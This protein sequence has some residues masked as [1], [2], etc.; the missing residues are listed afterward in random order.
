M[1]EPGGQPSYATQR[2]VRDPPA[3]AAARSA[4]LRAGSRL[5]GSSRKP[6]L[7]LM[8]SPLPPAGAHL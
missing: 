3:T 1:M 6:S 8:Q 4:S 2:P 7:Q 5:A